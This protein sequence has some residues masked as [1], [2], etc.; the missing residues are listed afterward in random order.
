MCVFSLRSGPELDKL[1]F[2]PPDGIL[3]V[4]Q[5]QPISCLLD[6]VTGMNVTGTFDLLDAGSRADLLSTEVSSIP[7]QVRPPVGS[8]TYRTAGSTLIV[9]S[10][11]YPSGMRLQRNLT[12]RILREFTAFS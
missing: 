1:H 10:Y 2:S 8:E 4:G 3:R 6:S 5:S 11:M 7:V 9:C 12:V